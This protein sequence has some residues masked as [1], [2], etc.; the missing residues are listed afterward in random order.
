V[1]CSECSATYTRHR[2]DRNGGNTQCHSLTRTHTTD[3]IATAAAWPTW[4]ALVGLMVIAVLNFWDLP[5]A[6]LIGVL[7]VSLVLWYCCNMLQ[8]AATHCNTLQHTATHCNTL[9]HTTTHYNTIQH[10]A[11]RSLSCPP[12]SL[13]HA[14]THCTTLQHTTAHYSTLQHA[15]THCNTLQHTTTHYNT[16]QHVVSP[17]LWYH[18]NM[19]QHAATHC[20]TLKHTVTHCK[21]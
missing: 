10:T 13:Q 15:A 20:N 14:A 12:V 9:Q 5:G 3:T 21:T 6:I 7:S 4:A 2:H 16:L 19:L 11:T 1:C 18:C 8:H 17:V